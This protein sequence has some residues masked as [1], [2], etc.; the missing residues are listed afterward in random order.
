MS[1]EHT[2]IKVEFEVSALGQG[3]I[4]VDGV[5]LSRLVSGFTL[6]SHVGDLVRLSLQLSGQEVVAG[7]AEAKVLEKVQASDPDFGELQPLLLRVKSGDIIVVRYPGYLSLEAEHQLAAHLQPVLP[8]GAR[9][10][11]LQEGMS[12]EV[13]R[14][15]HG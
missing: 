8:D 5:D 1:T 6:R 14:P 10:M 3:S 7:T 15:D 12:L 13:L 4:K 2:P 9:V 11:V